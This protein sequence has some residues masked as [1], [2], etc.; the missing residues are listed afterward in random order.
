MKSGC[1]VCSEHHCI[2]SYVDS[3]RMISVQ[4][5][6][7]GDDDLRTQMTNLGIKNSALEGLDTGEATAKNFVKLAHY[8]MKAGRLENCLYY[9]EVS[10]SLNPD[11]VGAL[12]SLGKCHLMMGHWM[13][14]LKVESD[15]QT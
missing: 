1:L 15:L 12:T 8:H 2:S 4:I 6:G 7:S 9:L 3:S 14:A 5:K 10:L 11:L 13:D